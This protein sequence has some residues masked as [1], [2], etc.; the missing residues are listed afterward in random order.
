MMLCKKMQQTNISFE[1]ISSTHWM[2][3]NLKM[4][5]F[6]FS[7][8]AKIKVWMKKWPNGWRAM[9]FW[10]DKK[11]QSKGQLMIMRHWKSHCASFVVLSILA[12]FCCLQVMNFVLF[13]SWLWQH[14]LWQ[15]GWVERNSA[16]LGHS[17]C[18]CVRRSTCDKNIYV[19]KN[20][21][22][23]NYIINIHSFDPKPACN[24]HN[25]G[26]LSASSLSQKKMMLLQSSSSVYWRV[27]NPSVW[28]PPLL[29]RVRH[30]QGLFSSYLWWSW[31][32]NHP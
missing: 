5:Q 21:N 29:Q 25:L 13:S 7:M 24:L 32:G 20:I 8:K 6:F 4:C 12:S 18:V 14:F 22:F 11:C 1:M 19:N 9:I 17:G 28:A 3:C 26:I 2:E 10:T 16:L 27:M 23:H 31:I 30:C 15:F